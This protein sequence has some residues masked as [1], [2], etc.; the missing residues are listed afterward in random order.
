MSPASISLP[1][2]VVDP[3]QST[4]NRLA[5]QLG[6]H[7]VP[8]PSIADLE[9]R[10]PGTPTV[11]VLG[12]SCATTRGSSEPRSCCARRP[13]VGAVLVANELTTELFQR[14]IRV[15]RPRRAPRTHRDRPAQRRG[16]PR[17]RDAVGHGRQRPGGQRHRPGHRR[18]RPGHHGVLHQ[19]RRRQ[20]AWSP[21]NLGVTLAMRSDRAGR[22]RRRRPAV[23]RRGGHAQA[24]PAAHHRRRRRRHR[25]PR[26]RHA[27]EPADP[28]RPVGPAGAARAARAGLRRPDQRRVH[29]ADHR[30]RCGRSAPSS[31]ST[32]RRTSTRSC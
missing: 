19:G 16:P 9:A 8:F 31:W 25:A 7:A 5:M 28:A 18:A 15:G 20:V 27:A 13:E 10:L 26:R 4:R 12:P 11:V 30:D 23:R 29:D 1:V 14:A 21:C 17:G 24:G 32:P 22:A 6:E 2:A 3:D